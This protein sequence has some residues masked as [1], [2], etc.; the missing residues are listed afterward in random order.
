MFAAAKW[1]KKPGDVNRGAKWEADEVQRDERLVLTH[2]LLALQPCA[3][4]QIRETRVRADAFA[5]EDALSV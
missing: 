1:R 4:H 5:S 2:R 3:S